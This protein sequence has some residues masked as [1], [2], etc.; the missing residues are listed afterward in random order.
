MDEHGPAKTTWIEPVGKEPGESGQ[1]QA[2]P[3]EEEPIEEHAAEEQPSVGEPAEGGSAQGLAGEAGAGPK[4]GG[5]PGRRAIMVAAIVAVI[6]IVVAVVA[7]VWVFRQRHADA[8]EGCGRAYQAYTAS[9]AKQRHEQEEARKM[10]Q[11]TPERKVADPAVRKT[12]EQA[13]REPAGHTAAVCMASQDTGRLD[14][15]RDGLAKAASINK[16]L[17][18]R[19]RA[20]AAKVRA[21]V[22]AKSLADGKKG[23]EDAIGSAASLLGGSDG[24]VADNA[25]RD[26][27]AKAIDAARQASGRKDVTDPKTYADAKRSL[28][29]A[30]KAVNDSISQKQAADAAAAAQAA[31]PAAPATGGAGTGYKSSG[32]AN[33]TSGGHQSNGSSHTGG[34]NGGSAPVQAP[35]PQVPQGGGSSNSGGSVDMGGSWIPGSDPVI[36]NP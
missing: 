14:R 11:A 8:L 6:V 23:L 29:D 16:G 18:G 3:I 4:N 1:A 17:V 7:G 2:Q 26:A 27:L 22:K 31:A 30:V 28:D 9:A 24:R 19:Y 5:R 20:A 15:N 34:T 10:L 32:R 12:L 21:S 35:H 33:G 13:V 36:T 25:V